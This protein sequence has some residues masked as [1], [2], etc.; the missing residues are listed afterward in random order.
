LAVLVAVKVSVLEPPAEPLR[1]AGEN[2]AVTP[3]GTPAIERA[4]AELNPF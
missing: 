4:T 3:A 1:L 2:A